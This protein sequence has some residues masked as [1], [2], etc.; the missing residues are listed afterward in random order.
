MRRTILSAAAPACLLVGLTPVSATAD[1]A[2]GASATATA[3]R[4]SD[5]V[6]I[7]DTSAKADGSNSEAK[8]SVISVGGKPFPGG[9]ESGAGT[10][11]S[12]SGD[13]ENKGALIDTV[14]KSPVRVQVAPW[15]ARAN[16]AE[17]SKTGK[18]S[19]SASAA[20]ATVEVPDHA[21]VKL[22]TSDASA[23]HTDM[24]STGK[25]TSDA[26]DITVGDVHL[27]LLHSEVDSNAKG[28]SYLVNL[29]GTKIGTREQLGELCALDLS[30]VAAVSC[31]TASGGTANGIA[32]GT[33]EVLGV[34]S[35]LPFNPASAFATTGT[36]GTGTEPSI[37]ES[38][39]AA[40]PATEA[41]RAA[42]APQ[43]AA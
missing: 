4:L 34:Q 17:K 41:P 37:L 21:N 20:L 18:R 9:T 31:L 26:A 8:A 25:S 12:E 27:V 30:G 15:K 38:V 2:P 33:A 13:G 28:D 14:D 35:Q 32:S 39:A 29:N 24:Q 36:A 22:L 3:A 42:A 7:S 10:G 11:G 23:E 43:P 19:S 5:Q 6:A 40:V 1:V 16:G